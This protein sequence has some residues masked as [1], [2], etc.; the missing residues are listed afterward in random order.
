MSK[1]PAFKSHL[2]LVAVAVMKHH[3]PGQLEEEGV[4]CSLRFQRERVLMTGRAESTTD[5]ALHHRQ[6]AERAIG[7]GRGCRLWKPTLSAI[8]PPARLQH[9]PKQHHQLDT[10]C[11]NTSAW[12]GTSHFKTLSIFHGGMSRGWWLKNSF[13]SP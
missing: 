2:A 13:H 7:L 4:Y 12:A 8:L 3:M 6:E 10:K 9:L 11:S 5:H 1:Q